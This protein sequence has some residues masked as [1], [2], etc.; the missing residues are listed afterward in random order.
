M[1]HSL[2]FGLVAYLS[3]GVNTKGDLLNNFP[4]SS[5][6]TYLFELNKI[7]KKNKLFHC[8]GLPV[9]VSRV[10]V[11]VTM[12]LSVPVDCYVSRHCLH[13]LI[14]RFRSRSN[15][16][17]TEIVETGIPLLSGSSNQHI[18][19][20]QSNKFNVHEVMPA[21]TLLDCENV[22]EFVE[23]QSSAGYSFGT[24]DHRAIDISTFE[25]VTLT[26]ILWG[27]TL[28]ISVCIEDLGVVMGITGAL[29]AS[30]VGYVVPAVIYLQA[31]KN[32]NGG[33]C[34]QVGNVNGWI[35]TIN[36][37]SQFYIPWFMIVFGFVAAFT[38]VGTVMFPIS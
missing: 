36:T 25:H 27:S 34:C 8:S 29:C 6:S 4:S 28:F 14:E 24:Y 19:Y 37:Q 7:C 30:L 33:N 15:E 17:L 23:E 11:G 20:N 16:T 12:L 18:S 1:R 31:H 26:I 10:L 5:M 21:N 22:S 32:E 2:L 9:N 38:G 35:H 13:S 3:F